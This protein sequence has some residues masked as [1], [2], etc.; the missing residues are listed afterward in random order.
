MI[1]DRNHFGFLVQVID[2][3]HLN[4]VSGYAECRVFHILE[5]LNKASDENMLGNQMGAV[6]M[7]RGRKKN[8]CVISMIS[9]S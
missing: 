5:F 3:G 1:L 8:I 9:F 6:H 7:K 2:R 4:A